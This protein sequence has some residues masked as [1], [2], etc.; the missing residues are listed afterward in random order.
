MDRKTGRTERKMK[1]CGEANGGEER[2]ERGKNRNAD[3]V[4][5]SQ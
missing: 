4:C 5:C 1:K 3:T 2:V